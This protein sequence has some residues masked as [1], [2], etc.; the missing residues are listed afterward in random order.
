MKLDENKLMDLINFVQDRKGHDRRYA[1][2]PLKIE[3]ELGWKPEMTFDEG[4]E[5]T[6]KWYTS[7]DQWWDRIISGEYI[8]YYNLQYGER[9]EK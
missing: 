9:L 6:I 5:E 8:R 2:D 4:I 3:K 1:I 7:N